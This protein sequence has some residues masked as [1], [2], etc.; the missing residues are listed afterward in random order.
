[1]KLTAVINTTAK[2]IIRHL[3]KLPVDEV[4]TG[5]QFA[6]MI[7]I[8]RDMLG[9]RQLSSEYCHRKSTNLTYYGHPKAIAALRKGLSLNED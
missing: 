3:H 1:M 6:A 2:G 7:G 8:S 9:R 5:A 4:L